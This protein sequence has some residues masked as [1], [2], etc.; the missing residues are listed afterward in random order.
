MDSRLVKQKH[1]ENSCVTGSCFDT[2]GL[3]TAAAYCIIFFLQ[4]EHIGLFFYFFFA[5]ACRIF[6]LAVG[7]YHSVRVDTRFMPF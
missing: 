4:Q 1:A 2:V 6:F 5:A 7:I 3:M